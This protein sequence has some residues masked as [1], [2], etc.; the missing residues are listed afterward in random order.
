MAI[1]TLTTDL[2]SRDH[3]SASL[4]GTLLCQCPENQLIDITHD[5]SPFNV[6]EAAFIL[7]SAYHK[8]PEGTIHLVGVDPEGGNHQRTLVMRLRGHYFVG[9]D[10]GVMSLIREGESCDCIVVDESGMEN[11]VQGR[12]FLA[13]NRLAPVACQLAA[14]TAMESLGESHEVRE[15]LW[16]EPSY[17]ETASVASSSTSTISGTPS[18]TFAKPASSTPRATVPSRSSSATCGSSAS[19]PPTPTSPKAKPWPFSPTTATSKSPFA[20]GPPLNSS[21]SRSR[22]CSP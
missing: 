17:T 4:K 22:T 20:K 18:P 6:L 8:F 3:Y 19:S 16:G 11:G 10:N 13:Q 1:I 21:A 2:G 9:P 12:A 7:K 14:G 5:I 15:Y